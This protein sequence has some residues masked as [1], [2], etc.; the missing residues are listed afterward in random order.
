ME[1]DRDVGSIAGIVGAVAGQSERAKL[2][3]IL[4]ND[5]SVDDV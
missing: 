2:A 1:R 4:E 3:I 5:E